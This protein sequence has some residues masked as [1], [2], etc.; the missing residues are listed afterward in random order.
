M[1]N[2]NY[3]QK[4][5]K[6]KIKYLL[7]KSGGVNK[8]YYFPKK[9]LIVGDSFIRSLDL[10]VKLSGF[11]KVFTGHTAHGL[12]RKHENG[13][14]EFIDDF[15]TQEHVDLNCI[16]FNFGNV[17]MHLSYYYKLSKFLKT[18]TYIDIHN[19][20][21]N[22]YNKQ[23]V[24]ELCDN[25]YNFLKLY[26]TIKTVIVICPYYS[27]IDI[28]HMN[29][30]LERYVF[31]DRVIPNN[32]LSPIDFS[33]KI[34]SFNNRK[35]LIDLFCTRITELLAPYN[36][37]QVININHKLINETNTSIKDE[38]KLEDMCDIHLHWYPIYST[39]KDLIPCDIS[40][41]VRPIIRKK[42]ESHV[43]LCPRHPKV[44]SNNVPLVEEHPK[45]ESN[46]IHPVEEHIKVESNY[47]SLVE[48]HPKVEYNDISPI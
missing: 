20:D 27:P 35:N 6:Y 37:Y 30:I 43:P 5:Y 4:Y 46:T 16:I 13:V 11:L 15:I 33:S 24:Y 45:V 28:I 31:T 29:D 17:D 19:F 2:I 39:L 7:L 34:L 14:F 22:N 32:L 38:Y 42:Y 48:E 12:I 40:K 8:A 26:H 41:G 25:Y 9:L 18:N 23:F 21:I 44:E 1:N 36:N 3:L 47:V 10:S